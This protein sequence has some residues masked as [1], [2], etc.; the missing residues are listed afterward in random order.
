MGIA[1][2]NEVIE[3]DPALK[4]QQVLGSQLQPTQ[5][6]NNTLEADQPLTLVFPVLPQAQQLTAIHLMQTLDTVARHDAVITLDDV[7]RLGHLN[8]VDWGHRQLDGGRQSHAQVFVDSAR[9]EFQ[10]P[11]VR[12]GNVR[13][14]R[15]ADT[16]IKTVT[17]GVKAQAKLVLRSR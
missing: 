4:T 7:N 17:L 11:R 13:G 3:H 2:A 15:T 10:Q 1:V 8:Q 9:L 6:F 12:L 14:G 5:C 16:V